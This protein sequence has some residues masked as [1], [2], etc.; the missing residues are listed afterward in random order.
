MNQ[1]LEIVVRGRK[2]CW[3]DMSVAVKQNC[4][5]HSILSSFRTIQTIIGVA[6]FL[7]LL[8]ILHHSHTHTHLQASRQTPGTVLGV[9][10]LPGLDG[11][12]CSVVCNLCN[13]TPLR[14]AKR[15]WQ[16]C[17]G[18]CNYRTVHS[19]FSLFLFLTYF[20]FLA[21]F[22]F[23]L[24]KT[25]TTRATTTTT[26]TEANSEAKV[27]W[28]ERD[29]TGSRRPSFPPLSLPASKF[30]FDT[31]TKSHCEVGVMKRK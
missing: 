1:N 28:M 31:R 23:F 12:A 19:F 11:L 18:Y 14:A 10:L 25:S 13:S 6:S 16:V 26:T 2:C 4:T 22:F 5:R 30:H 24:R 15:K 21:P 3:D 7:S 27:R 29:V 20:F 9:T 17:L 8:P